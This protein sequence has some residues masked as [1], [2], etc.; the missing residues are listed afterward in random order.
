M[1]TLFSLQAVSGE[2][3]AE[4]V[5]THSFKVNDF[6][7]SNQYKKNMPQSFPKEI[8]SIFALA[9]RKGSDQLEDWIT[10][11]Y[12]RYG[13]RVDI[14]GVANMKG[15]PKMLRP[16]LR[17]IFKKSIEYPVM[18]DWTGATCEAFKY[19]AG[20]ADIF[21]VDRNGLVVHRIRGEANEQK[22]KDCYAVIDRLIKEKD[23]EAAAEENAQSQGKDP[24]APESTSDAP[25]QES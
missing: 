10:P 6:V 7:L 11:F 5:S 20:V 8:I 21:I 4:R 9:D 13:E 14:C 16:M 1:L 23:A 22:L 2:E 15:L 12:K 25:M 3:Q 24:Q 19:T 18:M 17:G